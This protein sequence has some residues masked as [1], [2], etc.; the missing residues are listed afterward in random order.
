[1][2]VDRSVDCV[3]EPVA[4]PAEEI[5]DAPLVA[6]VDIGPISEHGGGDAAIEVGT[7]R[8]RLEEAPVALT[9]VGWAT[10]R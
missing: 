5:E 10:P 7:Q 6:D 8:R 2:L 3:D 4:L 1:M 9:G